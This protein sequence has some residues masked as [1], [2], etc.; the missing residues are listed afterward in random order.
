MLGRILLIV[1]LVFVGIWLVRKLLGARKTK[2]PDN[3]KDSPD[4]L[5]KCAHCGVHMPL[6]DALWKDGR[7]FCS[8]THRNLGPK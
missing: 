2:A 5:V 3:V 4:A 8:M 1:A 6:T 7:A